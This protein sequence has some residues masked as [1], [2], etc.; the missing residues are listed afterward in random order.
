MST[1]HILLVEDDFLNRRFYKK[2][3]VENHYDVNEAKST[4]EAI[5][6]LD[7]QPVDLIIL[8]IHLGEN[9]PDG[10]SL[11]RLIRDKYRKPFIYLTAYQTSEIINRA[12][13]TAPSS[14]LTKPFKNVDF[15]ASIVV[16]MHQHQPIA[17]NDQTVTVKDGEF[18]M[19]LPLE[20]I[21]YIES[22]GNY[23]LYHANNK[24]YKNRC[25]IKGIL[26]IIPG[27]M[28]IQTHRAFIVNKGKIT[29]HSGRQ[30]IVN[31]YAVPISKT[32]LQ[33]QLEQLT[34]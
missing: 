1:K 9:E 8:D 15:L 32:F 21:D 6:I 25:T 16:A 17:K 12:V 28:F 19:E 33:N 18:N 2:L 7:S 14:Y 26:E 24:I 23:L 10:I 27:D 4:A 13:L 22:E 29:K 20:Q 5:K 11:G 34:S 3:L 31:G 30:L